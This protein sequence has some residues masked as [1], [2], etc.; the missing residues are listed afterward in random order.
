MRRACGIIAIGAIALSASQFASAQTS[1]SDQSPQAAGKPA[2]RDQVKDALQQAGF[3]NIRIISES[4][5]VRA[6]DQNGDPVVMTI[7]PDSLKTVRAPT[8]DDEDE[9]NADEGGYPDQWGDSEDDGQTLAPAPRKGRIGKPMTGPPAAESDQQAQSEQN[10]AHGTAGGTP[11]GTADTAKSAKM[12]DKQVNSGAAEKAEENQTPSQSA[13]MRDGNE[14]QNQSANNEKIPGPPNGMT[15]EM[16]ESEQGS[17]NLTA[18]QRAEIWQRLGNQQDSNAPPGFQPRVGATVPPTMQ[19]K[20]LPSGVSSQ[21]PQ[22]RLYN[23]AMFNS[24]LL[25]VDP[26]TKKIVSIITE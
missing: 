13:K 11:N 18:P 14:G 23:Y 1:P 19:L 15:T 3:K 21:V 4:F 6:L 5:L 10:A 20:T 25:I 9:A 22:I 26:M 17:L 16:K 8:E 2:L 7:R 12:T 24:Q